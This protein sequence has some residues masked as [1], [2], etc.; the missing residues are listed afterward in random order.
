MLHP[1]Q[2]MLGVRVQREL[3]KDA[4]IYAACRDTTVEKLVTK[5]LEDLVARDVV[6]AAA[7]DAAPRA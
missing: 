2:V 1:G 5:F 4:Q 6:V 7:R 3:R